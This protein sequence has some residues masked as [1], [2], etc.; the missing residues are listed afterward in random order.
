MKD[1]KQFKLT[2]G[3]EIITEVLEWPGID[4]DSTELADMVVRN[5][6][7]IVAIDQTIDGHR[8]YTFRPWMIYQEG[9]D[10]YQTIN[11]NHII[12]EAN[13]TEKLLEQYVIALNNSAEPGVDRE[14]IQKKLEDYINN[15]RNNLAEKLQPY[16][17]SDEGPN[18][19]KFPGRVLH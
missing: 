7:K 16:D 19:I 2:N 1:I 15:L 3:E 6:Y 5:T 4:D 13:P 17:D 10:V 12:G 18:V 8:Y 9:D 14:A 11:V